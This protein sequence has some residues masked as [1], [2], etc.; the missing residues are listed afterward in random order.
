MYLEYFGLNEFP[1]AL[2]PNTDFYCNLLSHQEALDV[3]LVA[4][5]NGEGFTKIIGEV[6]TG[7][8]L[9]CRKLL[10][11]LEPD[12][13]YVTAYI[14]NP[15][16]DC[17]GLYETLAKELGVTIKAKKITQ[18]SLLKLLTDKLLDIYKE[19][20]MVV[21]LIDEAQALPKD[22]LESLRLLS[23]LETESKKLLHMVLFGQPELDEHLEED[24]LRQ[25]KQRITFSYYLK[26]LKRHELEDYI[27]NR[28]LKAGYKNYGSLFSKKICDVLFRASN[29]IPRLINVLCHKAL[30]A[31][32]GFGE[33]KVSTK[34]MVLAIK[35][36]ESTKSFLKK[37]NYYLIFYLT[38]IIEAIILIFLLR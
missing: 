6:G 9:L 3:A 25:L 15:N 32:Y 4:I 20:K 19:G 7:K 31:A 5:K 10:K 22:T 14:L 29:G 11:A 26:P 34:S 21:V 28:L 37:R 27:N 13:K 18:N 36:T 33:K 2:T 8:T 1:F 30:L 35:D 12:K 24:N 16:I 17:V 23:N 38:L